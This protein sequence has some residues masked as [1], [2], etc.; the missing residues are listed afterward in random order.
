M[1]YEIIINGTVVPVT[2][3]KEHIDMTEPDMQPE[4]T[5]RFKPRTLMRQYADDRETIMIQT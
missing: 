3:Y 5:V 1:K 2:E 4:I